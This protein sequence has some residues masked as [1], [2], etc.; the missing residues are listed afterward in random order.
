MIDDFY[1]FD[2]ESNFEQN[3]GSHSCLGTPPFSLLDPIIIIIIIYYFSL[4]LLFILLR[5]VPF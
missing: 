3:K 2:W 1:D 4:S 5:F